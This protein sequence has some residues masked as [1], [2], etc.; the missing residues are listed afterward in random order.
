VPPPKSPAPGGEWERD[1]L[2]RLAFAAVTEQRRARR[3]NTF[4]KVI[5]VGYLVTL[6]FVSLP[7]GWF[8][9]GG[10]D[11]HT[12]LVDVSGVISRQSEANAD[13][14]VGGLR[15][16]FEDEDTK[17]VI[18][19]VNSP[20]GSPVQAGYIYDEIRRLRKLHPDVPL[21][22]VI[23]DISASGGYYIAAAA[24]RI[25]ADKASVV[26]SIGVIMNGFGFVESMK[27]VGVERRAFTSGEN[28]ALLDPFAPL[29]EEE[30][31][32]MKGVLDNIHKQFVE[33]VRQGRG[34]RIKDDDKLF[35]GLIW[36][37]EQSVELGLVDELAS[38]GHVAREVIGADKVID[39]TARKGILDR[40]A[41]RIGTSI[42]QSLGL[43][44]GLE[45]LQLR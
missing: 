13:R 15:A 19:R 18:L 16:A 25:Y 9:F 4:F 31:Q 7:S 21:Y 34:D 26:G 43:Q 42:G 36:S 10:D 30:V 23:T 3:W 45:S 2:T 35:S 22:A 37:G 1:V 28:K 20:G 39:F 11:K 12:A 32:H 6:L 17:G 24:D 14:I 29:R 33:V 41:S 5:I 38:A 27:I 44:T 8:D 40:L